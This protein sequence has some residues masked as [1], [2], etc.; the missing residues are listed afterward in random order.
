M[1]A[2]G[3]GTPRPVS[4][5][6]TERT[7]LRV[8]RP[9]APNLTRWPSSD[10]QDNRNS[11]PGAGV[12]QIVRINGGSPAMRIVLAAIVV[13]ASC[14]LGA[15]ENMPPGGPAPAS[16]DSSHTFVLH[17]PG[18]AGNRWVDKQMTSGLRDAGYSGELLTYDWTDNEPGLSALRALKRNQSEAAKIA[19]II[20]AHYRT[21]PALRIV[22]TSHSGG[23]GLAIWALE[24]LPG[25]VK[26]DT[27]MLLSS[28]L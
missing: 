16:I 9:V 8:P 19:D 27:V 10:K 14:A 21:D 24:K 15:A 12:Y 25:D 7:G 4:F 23:T 18:I 26:V 22:L 28:A 20:T 1:G 5:R 3:R 17:L 2:T 11:W 6:H 13:F